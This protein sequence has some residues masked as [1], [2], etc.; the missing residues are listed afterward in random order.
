MSDVKRVHR[1][2]GKETHRAYAAPA[3]TRKILDQ[4]P[5]RTGF[6]MTRVREEDSVNRDINRDCVPTISGIVHDGCLCDRMR[7]A[8]TE[9]SVKT[10]CVF[11]DN[12]ECSD[13]DT[14]K[15]YDGKIDVPMVET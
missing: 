5:R 11:S 2:R 3:L 4:G 10:R 14:F 7:S 8:I 1:E 6:R 15:I 9:V 13:I 12:C